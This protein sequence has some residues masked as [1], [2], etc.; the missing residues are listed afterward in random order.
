MLTTTWNKAQLLWHISCKGGAGGANATTDYTCKFVIFA[1]GPMHV[2]RFPNI[3][4][5]DKFAGKV[6]HSCE[7][8]HSVDLAS[9][10]V[11]VIG[12]G[13]SAIQFVPEIQP[14]VSRA[15]S[16]S[17]DLAHLLLLASTFC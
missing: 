3:P 7:W 12:S 8:D 6:F 9:K 13:A 2:P 16:A 17:T 5:L 10:R 4:G 11:A 15:A 1:T 14:Q